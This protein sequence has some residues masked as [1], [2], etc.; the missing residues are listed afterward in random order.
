MENAKVNVKT[1]CRTCANYRNRA[2]Y[3]DTIITWKQNLKT[4]VLVTVQHED[5][6]HQYDR[7][8]KFKE[9]SFLQEQAKQ[10]S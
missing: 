1:P 10:M 8:F 7:E 6:G 2:P 5:C 9:W 3:Q 4:T